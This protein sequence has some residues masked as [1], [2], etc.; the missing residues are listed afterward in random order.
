MPKI[1][2]SITISAV[3]ATCAIIS[4]VLTA[5]INNHHLYKMRKLD[6][7]LEKEKASAFYKRGIF[8]NYLKIAGK[9]VT[10]P[11][12]ET[13]SKYGEIYP[14]ALIYF[15]DY[16]QTTLLQLNESILKHDWEIA[17][18]H[19]AS[20]TPMIRDILQKM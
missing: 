17:Q 13:L 14:L 20:I 1:D 15:P 3:I 16:L 12:D 11:N 18:M 9:C 2:L 6:I 8:E 5:L 10:T 4:P 19:L 7:K